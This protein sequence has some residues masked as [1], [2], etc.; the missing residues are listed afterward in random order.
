MPKQCANRFL[1]KHYNRNLTAE[2]DESFVE[3]MDKV[4]RNGYSLMF[5]PLFVH[6]FDAVKE[7]VKCESV[8]ITTK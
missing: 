8:T 1:L 2:D 3:Y 6:H 5:P 7:I 4:K